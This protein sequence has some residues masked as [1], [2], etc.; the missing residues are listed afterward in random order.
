V[1]VDDSGHRQLTG[2][3]SPADRVASLQHLHVDAVTG[4]VDR[5][6]K[7][8]GPGA[9]DDRAGHRLARSVVT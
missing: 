6:G 4:E 3:R 7:A 9:D 2:A 8:V 1:V 5:R